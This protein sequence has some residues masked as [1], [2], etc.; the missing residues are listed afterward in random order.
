MDVISSA[1]VHAIQSV[2]NNPSRCEFIY[3]QL[4]IYSPHQNIQFLLKF[5]NKTEF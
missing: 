3:N 1:Y 4:T 2:H 5:C